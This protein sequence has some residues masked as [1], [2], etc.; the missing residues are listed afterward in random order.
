[1]RKSFTILIAAVIVL[2]SHVNSYA[3]SEAAVLFLRIAAGARAA[4]MGEAF[5][6]VADDATAT[7]WN[8]AGLGTYP[9]SNKWF[10]ISIPK[11]IQ[12]LK[13]MVVF[14]NE[15]S[16]LDYKRFDIWAL[17]AKGL[18]K[19]SSEFGTRPGAAQGSSLYASFMI[20]NQDKWA[21]SDIIETSADQTAE[22]VLRQYVGLAGEAAE[23]KMPALLEKLGSA[24]NPY[25]VERIDSFKEGVLAGLGENYKGKFEFDT[26]FATLHDAYNRC[27]VDWQSF[28]RAEGL[29]RNAIKDSAITEGEADKIL[30]ALE[31]SKSKAFPEQLTVP[32]NIIFEGTPRDIAADDNNLWLATDSGLYRYNGRNWQRFGINEGLPTDNIMMVTL[33]EKKAY[34]GTDRGLVVYDAGAFRYFGGG[35]AAGLPEKPVQ[36]I[37]IAN[38]KNVWAVIDSDLYHFNGKSWKNYYD[39]ND[40][41]GETD[42]SLYEN[43]KLYGTPSEK[44]IYLA[45]FS[46]LNVPGAVPEEKDPPAKGVKISQLINHLGVVE[47]YRESLDSAGAPIIIDSAV[48]P[49]EST[50]GKKLRIPYTAGFKQGI[51]AMAWDER[52]G[53]W[54]GTESGLLRFSGKKWYR[55]GYREYNPETDQTVYNLALERVKGDSS[56]A[57]RLAMN[58]KVVNELE[59]DTVRAGQSLML[60]ANPAGAKING[61]RPI[62]NRMFFATE[63]G[64][65]WYDDRWSRYN[66]EQLGQKN[67]IGIE[68][69]GSDAWYVTDD[70]IMVLA[71]ARSELSL[72]HVNW[73][74]EL[75]SDIYYEFLSY[76][77]NVEGW[78][79]VGGNLTFLSYG[80]IIRTD[81]N[82]AIL[83]EFS[84]FDAAMT[85]SYG[86]ALSPSL[87]GGLSAKIIY[88]HLSSLGS[89]RE[90]G[91][92]TST[93]LAL[94]AGILY[95]LHRRISLGAAV[96]NLGPDISYIDVSQSDP[97][98]RNLAVGLA[99]KFIESNY[100]K[101]LV[102]VEANKSLVNIGDGFSQELKE[103]VLNGGLEYWYGSFIALRGGYIYDQDGQIKTPT[104]GFGLA[105]KIFQFDFA[106]IPSNDQVPLANTARFS[107]K[108]EM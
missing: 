39:Y 33:H 22:S 53:I 50:P 16:N 65:I 20:G 49:K 73:L 35:D 96:T 89:G 98:P 29:Y 2:A 34:I 15:S 90:K 48:I 68:E 55:Y 70:K 51:T 87:S 105:Y 57:E 5:V 107:L 18:V 99:W 6:A 8:P 104:F 78:G 40:V 37:A 14:K 97:L 45:K 106:Y 80:R 95:R 26:A 32:F 54:I 28:E 56:R 79:T 19:N 46:A 60:Y 24:N 47:A 42:S 64:T 52:N 43:M 108:I 61:I 103:V 25:P 12:P 102:T 84:A 4:G 7:H 30:F 71:G 76:V 72:M 23:A 91:S 31:K 82:N 41:L 93:G 13:K 94:D 77:K 100:N 101:A 67:T 88:S 38:D 1:M 11:D 81:E 44:E 21:M 66:A 62:N 74:P 63:S 75:A 10:E 59:S 86:T 3:V 58:I 27:L 69:R 9:L 17:T 36:G 83:G 92:G 85:L